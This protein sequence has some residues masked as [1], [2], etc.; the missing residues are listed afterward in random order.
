MINPQMIMQLLPLFQQN[1]QALAAQNGLNIQNQNGNNPK[2]MVQG[3]LD[4][5][6]I[7]Q[8]TFNRAVIMARQMGYN[9]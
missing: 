1:P 7:D 4:S 2:S 3:L 6:Q 9:V 8:N 5:G